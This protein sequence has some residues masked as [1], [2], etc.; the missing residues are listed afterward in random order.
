MKRERGKVISKKYEGERRLTNSLLWNTNK[1]NDSYYIYFTLL[2]C[3]SIQL[4]LRLYVLT[5]ITLVGLE[6]W[7][8]DRFIFNSDSIN[9]YK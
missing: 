6:I 4:S 2:V 3:H 5:D 8:K 1:S 9:L 7:P